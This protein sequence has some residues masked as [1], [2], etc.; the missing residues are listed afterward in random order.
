M[1]NLG[2]KKGSSRVAGAFVVAAVLPLLLA[3]CGAAKVFSHGERAAAEGQWDEAVLAYA[4]A[5]ALNPDSTRYR[6]SLNRA[7][8]TASI[9]HFNKARR[10]LEAGQLELAIGELQQTNVLDPT[11]DYAR[12]ELEKAL[13]QWQALRDDATKTELELAK[14]RARKERGVPRLNPGSNIPIILKFKEEELG[15]IYEALSKASGINFLYDNK[16]D[17]KKKVS[18]DLTNV[19]FENAMSTLMLMNKHFFKVVDENTI[20][21]ADDTQQKRREIEDE[22]IRTFYLSNADVKDVQT[23]LRTLLDARK[24]VQNQQLN[25]ITIR[26]TPNIIAIAE[27]II[28][29]NDKSKAELLIDV[30]LMEI[31]NTISETLGIN[32]SSQ[33]FSVSYR[34][35]ESATLNN[36]GLLRQ[37]GNWAIG[38]IPSV[39]LDFLKSDSGTQ[40]IAHPQLRVTEGEKANL[41]IGDSVPIPT[42]SFNTAGTVGSSIVPITSFTYQEVGIVIEIEPRVHHNNEI[43][44]KLNVEVSQLGDQV[45]TGQNQSAPAINTRQINTVIRLKNGETNLLAG[46]ISEAESSGR[47]G[48]PGLVDTPILQRLFTSQTSTV[49]KT[50]LVLTLT[51]QIIRTPDIREEDLV[52][53]FI[54]TTNNPHLR[55]KASSP[56]GPDPFA[57]NPELDELIASQAAEASGEPAPEAAGEGKPSGAAEEPARPTRQPSGGTEAP[58]EP[59]VRPSGAEPGRAPEATEQAP[60]PAVAPPGPEQQQPEEAKAPQAGSPET[61]VLEDPM[62]GNRMLEESIRPERGAP[63]PTPAGQMRPQPPVKEFTLSLS[64]P[65]LTV[66]GGGGFSFNIKVTGA[67]NLQKVSMVVKYDP[68]V[69]D[70]DRGLEGVLM[71]GDG[72]STRFSAAKMGP[73]TV[74]VNL[75]RLGSRRGT[76][77]NGPIASLRFNPVAPGQT[78]ITIE[79]V[80]AADPAGQTIPVEVQGAEVTV[81]Q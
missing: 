16:L 12:V 8:Q 30:E 11:N 35:G 24:I 55:G 71:R 75:Q 44:L 43:S 33:R 2:P 59:G 1:K 58:A 20:L 54:G 15:K 26:D 66:A 4:R 67:S 31:S 19:T 5:V 29:S 64:P 61:R 14:E 49:R 56:F 80:S 46:L 22:V 3:G 28:E 23:L 52:P 79:Q 65:K 36:L 38:P 62:T 34:G 72:T 73:G 40:V 50:D 51:P 9:V 81:S 32:L 17:L 48:F 42:T 45:T 25:A 47:S 63:T 18:V 74:K 7:K 39:T 6:M 68:A 10:Y 60:A 76:T 41:H 53:L 78:K 37:L 57:P 21:L 13:I 77:G 69:A 70:F 27:K